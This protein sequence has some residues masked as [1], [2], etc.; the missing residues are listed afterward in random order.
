VYVLERRVR[1][2]SLENRTVTRRYRCDRADGVRARR[3]PP[4]RGDAR[5]REGALS[6]RDGVIVDAR[7]PDQYAGRAG[8]QF[9][10]GHIGRGGQSFLAGRPGQ[11]GLRHNVEGGET[12]CAPAT[13]RR[14]SLRQSDHRLCNGGLESSHVYFALHN[15]LGYPRVRVYEWIVYGVGRSVSSYR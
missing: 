14:A 1:K 2:W 8:A 11:G 12:S 7:N 6:A 3:V 15:L 13:W 9:R 5:G 10:R 4:D